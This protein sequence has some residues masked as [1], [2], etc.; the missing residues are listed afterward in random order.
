MSGNADAGQ[1][2]NHGDRNGKHHNRDRHR[3]GG[4][5]VEWR[6][7]RPRSCN[8][9]NNGRVSCSGGVHSGVCS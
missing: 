2:N 1:R 8:A 7:N 5:H 6:M 4:R 3:H 9:G